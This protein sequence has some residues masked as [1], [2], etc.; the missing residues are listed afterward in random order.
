MRQILLELL[1]KYKKEELSWLLHSFRAVEKGIIDECIDMTIKEGQNEF[2]V[3]L[4]AY[5]R[6]N[7]KKK[8]KS[9]DL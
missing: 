4:M 2:T 1:R 3:L 9:F 6:K 8:E 5:R 7:Y